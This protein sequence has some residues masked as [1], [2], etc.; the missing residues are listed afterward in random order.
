MGG[1]GGGGGVAELVV[2]GGVDGE[3]DA[4]GLG[5][6]A[7]HH[8]G[9][10]VYVGAGG[11]VGGVL[12]DGFLVFDGLA[13][14]EVFGG[15]VGFVVGEKG[16]VGEGVPTAA[17]V[18]LVDVGGVV[19]YGVVEGGAAGYELELDG[20]GGDGGDEGIAGE[21]DGWGGELHGDAAREGGGVG[22]FGAVEWAK[23]GLVL[24]ASLEGE[25]ELKGVVALIFEI[26][27]AT[28][29]LDGG[30]W[31]EVGGAAGEVEL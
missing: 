17:E 1:E 27:V 13:G 24:G 18:E 21:V 31:G 8:G 10:D 2:G 3:A 6:K 14:F 20:G 23:D 7:V 12:E 28:G 25:L 30:G 26:G 4:V 5:G 16:D 9:G 19:F 11:D 29:E 22:L 15:V